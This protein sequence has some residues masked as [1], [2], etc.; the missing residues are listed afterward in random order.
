MAAYLQAVALGA[1]PISLLVVVLIRL[2][3]VLVLVALFLVVCRC[4]AARPLP[5]PLLFGHVVGDHAGARHGRREARH[6]VGAKAPA[7]EKGR[8]PLEQGQRR[9]DLGR[10]VA[11][12]H[13]ISWTSKRV[14][15]RREARTRYGRRGGCRLPRSSRGCRRR[16]TP[17]P[18]RRSQK[19]LRHRRRLR[20]CRPLFLRPPIACWL[21]W[22]GSGL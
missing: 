10:A 5:L 6:V 14:H 18:P 12:A 16:S 13:D 3:F 17:R 20:V 8:A 9:S 21:G 11:Q 7:T 4:A 1:K 15:M 22:R 2:L 19:R